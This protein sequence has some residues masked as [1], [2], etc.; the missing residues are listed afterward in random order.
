MLPLSLTGRKVPT[1]NLQL[2]AHICP[3]RVNTQRPR[4]SV[5]SAET[6][7]Q[8]VSDIAVENLCHE[9]QTRIDSSGTDLLF[10]E[11]YQTLRTGTSFL[12]KR[13]GHLQIEDWP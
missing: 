4:L 3:A 1:R 9:V 11:Y 8:T 7:G 6:L 13:K 10:N 12:S 5:R 2:T